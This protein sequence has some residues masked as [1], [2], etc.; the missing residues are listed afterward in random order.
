MGDYYILIRRGSPAGETVEFYA[1]AQGDER[2]TVVF[3][4]RDSA[5]RFVAGWA[6]TE[7]IQRVDEIE[8]LSRLIDLFRS[9]VQRV[10]ID[11]ERSPGQAMRQPSCSLPLLLG[12]LAGTLRERLQGCTAV[13]A[14]AEADPLVAYRCERCQKVRRQLSHQHRPECCGTPMQIISERH[15]PERLALG[16]R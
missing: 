4:S 14:Q 7:E 5:R 15:T 1:G 3:T 11:P 8:L 9:G 2:T 12:D 16:Q 13:A 6:Q 10:A